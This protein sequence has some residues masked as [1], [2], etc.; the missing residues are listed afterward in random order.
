MDAKEKLNKYISVKGLRHTEQ[1]LQILE[2]FWKTERHLSTQELFDLI[3][4]RHQEI[5]YA[6]VARTMKIMED[7]GICQRVDFGDGVVRFEH[8]LG[9]EHHDHLICTRCGR[10]VEIYNR[11]LENLQDKLIKRHGFKQARH[12]LDI[13]GICP[14]CSKLKNKGTSK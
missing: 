9:H 13:F 3:R 10:F 2:V 14:R 1:R 12:K 6:T 5:G 11:E 7:A 8:K 4:R